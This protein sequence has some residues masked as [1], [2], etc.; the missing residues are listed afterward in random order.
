VISKLKNKKTTIFTIDLITEE[1]KDY[2]D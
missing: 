1:L 2:L